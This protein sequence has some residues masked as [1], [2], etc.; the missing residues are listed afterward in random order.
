MPVLNHPAREHRGN[1]MKN[2]VLILVILSCVML[3]S[4]SAATVTVKVNPDGS[5]SPSVVTIASGDTVEWTL[6]GPADSIIPVN[7]DGVSSGVCSAIKPYSATDPNDLTGPMPLAVSGIFSL[8]PIDLGFAV[9]PATSICAG[10]LPPAA[11]AGSQA[12][13][14]GAQ[15]GATM[16]VTWQ[17]PSLT[18]VFI[19][20]L[21][22]DVQ[23]APGTAD[24]SF[25]FTILDREVNKAVK[26]GK[27][28][29]LAI[30]AG[31]DGT[32]SW[33]FAN[34]VT[35]LQLQDSGDDTEGCGTR[36]TLGTPTEIAYQNRYYDLLR[37][38]AAHIK[39]R[40]DWYRALAYIKPSGANLQTHE[41]R[42]PKRCSIGCICNPQL[43]AQKGYT[44]AGLYAFYQA[45]TNLLVSE[46]PNKTMVYALIQDGFPRINN[47][48]GYE[49]S[50]GTSS[51]GGPLPGGI[52]QT[53]TILNNGQAAHGLLFAVA[54]NGLQTKKTDNCLNNIN[55]PGCP[56]KW[57]LQEGLEGQVTG[58]QTSNVD[59][60]SNPAD[61]ESALQNALSNSQGVYVELYEER[62]WEAVH[63]P[64]AIVDPLG[65]GRTM[66]QWATELHNRRRTLF[67]SLGDPFPSKYRHTFTRT[68]L[69][70]GNQ[71]LYYIHGSKCGV[72]SSV[73]GAV[74]ILPPGGT[75]TRHRAAR[76]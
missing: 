31:D 29:S 48:G 65:S 58:W 70:A 67:P 34:G 18:G 43:F 12:L 19:R 57:V 17:D 55:G 7:W 27:V 68:T 72:G 40:A 69:S 13:C 20:L 42:L 45:Q 28:Y 14:R 50:D 3:S 60:V 56:N 37:K 23:I 63:Q 15:S 62:F 33:L 2:R 46:F 38:V 64:N 39:S 6:N 75:P 22:K 16:D 41:N 11:A 21:W 9:V 24:A 59:K 74:V 49:T 32:P 54:H 61:V 44:P 35:A 52:E 30:R 1:R 25:D 47:N 51:G 4:L 26:N 5:F 76:H 10:G 73:A 36:M 66:G 71:I 53:Q 8:S